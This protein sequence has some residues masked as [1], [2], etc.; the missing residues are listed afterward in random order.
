MRLNGELRER[1]KQYASASICNADELEVL[2]LQAG[3]AM[4]MTVERKARI[5]GNL[6]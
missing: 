1:I 5:Y 4:P 2:L 6:L 3:P